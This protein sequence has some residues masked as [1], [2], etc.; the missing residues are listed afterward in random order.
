[1]NDNKKSITIDLSALFILRDVL[2]SASHMQSGFLISHWCN[3]G[4]LDVIRV[5]N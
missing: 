4:R 2:L 1:M 3:L 5:Y